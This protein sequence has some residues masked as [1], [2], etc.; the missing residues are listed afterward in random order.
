MV[1]KHFR[2]HLPF[3]WS[4]NYKSLINPVP[5]PKKLLFLLFVVAAFL[6]SCKKDTGI[7]VNITPADLAS[8]NAQLKGSWLFPVETLTILDDKGNAMFPAQTLTASAFY[9]DGSSHADM[10]PD[11][12]TVLHGTYV[13]STKSA[14][15]IYVHINYPDG[16]SADYQVTMLNSSI[17]TLASSQPDVYFYNGRYLPT[18]AATSTTLQ[19]LT[20]NIAGNLIKV[21]VKN[22]SI[23][24]VK[25]FLTRK[26]DGKT[27]MMDSTSN[28]NKTYTSVFTANEGDHIRVDVIG[29]VLDTYINAYADGYPIA[30]D[31]LYISA[32]ETSTS[33]GWNVSFP[34]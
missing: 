19:R 2:Y 7:N 6:S 10:M 30:G 5:V 13:L 14:G 17:L 23:F 3:Y 21:T 12:Q 18:E 15:G 16:S 34:Q 4:S 31:L 1:T 22:D 20:G 24:S 32:H 28:V 25:V 9:F 29:Q 27:I 8:V 11:P 33:N 26:A